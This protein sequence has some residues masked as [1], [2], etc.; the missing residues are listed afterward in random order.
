MSA[1]TGTEDVLVSPTE[2]GMAAHHRVAFV[3]LAAV[4]V[5][6]PFLVYPVFAM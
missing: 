1:T 4:L 3:V 2:A 6:A 5:A